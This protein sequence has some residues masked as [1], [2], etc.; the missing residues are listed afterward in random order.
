V[1]LL[2]IGSDGMKL[3]EQIIKL[4]T[5][6]ISSFDFKDFAR[7]KPSFFTRTGGERQP[8]MPFEDLMFFILFH[9]K[10]SIPSALRRFFKD[11]GSDEAMS[12]QSLSQAREK[13]HS[14]AFKHLFTEAVKLAVEHRNET[15]N[16]YRVFANDGT[17]IALPDT[18]KILG[19]YGG[20]GKNADSPTA[21]ASALYDVLNDTLI[22]VAIE[23][24]KIDERTLAH[25]HISALSQLPIKSKKLLI[26][27][28][29]Y[30]SFDFIKRHEDEGLYYLMRV[31]R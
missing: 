22:D 8:K 1:Y 31:K 14:K 11:K 18:P 5:S 25:G 15:W 2:N 9:M 12:Q 24:L 27:D 20:T 23:P 17:K 19:F 28:R 4:T 29:G 13:V 26:Y 6:I 21:Q 3:T 7:T 10:C 16:G 30:P